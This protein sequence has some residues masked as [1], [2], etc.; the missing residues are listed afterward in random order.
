MR[1]AISGAANLGKSTLINDFLEEW[2]TYGREVTSYRDILKEKNLPHSKETTK[3]TQKAILEYMSKT[4]D[5]FKLGDKV[6]FDRCPLDNLVY[7]MWAMGKEIG[8]IDEAFVDECIPL[9]KEAMKKLDIIF[10]IPIT[11]YNKIDIEEN[12][13]RETDKTYIKEIDNFFKVIQR[14]YHEH[15][16]DNPFF[17][18]EDSPALIEVFGDRKERMQMIKLYLD[19]D[20]DLIGGDGKSD[21]FSPENIDMMEEL[22]K[23]QKFAKKEE[24]EI[25]EQIKKI[26]EMNDT[27]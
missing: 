11:K 20:G 7:S 1:I 27:N 2:P 22:L 9:V 18:R 12:G 17:P 19:K 24:D 3:E 6:I 21:V 15:P 4:L 10:F 16:Q 23:G 26:K 13:V 5:E 8:G 25:K 14:H